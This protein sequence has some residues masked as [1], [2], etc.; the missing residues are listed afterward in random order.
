M[1]TYKVSVQKRLYTTGAVKVIATNEDEAIENVQARI[2]RGNI[3]TSDVEWDDP[4]Y[5]ECSFDTTGDV[6]I[7]SNID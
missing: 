6:D 3:Q 1:P 4:T 2:Y 7:D 5:E